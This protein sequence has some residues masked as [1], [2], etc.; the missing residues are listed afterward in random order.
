MGIEGKALRQRLTF[1]NKVCAEGLSLTF[2]NS[3]G[4]EG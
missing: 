4:M 1:V 3:N 2:L